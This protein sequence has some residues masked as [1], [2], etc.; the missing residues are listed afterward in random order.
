MKPSRFT[1]EQMEEFVR[2]GYWGKP[3]ISDLWEEN[4]GKYPNEEALADSKN[5]FTWAEAKIWFNRV[6]LSLLE[7]GLKKDDVVV[8]QLPNVCE[9]MLISHALDRAGLLG[10]PTQMTMRHKEME[11]ILTKTGAVAIV[12]IPFFHNF[13]YYQ[14]IQEVRE[15]FPQLKY[16][17]S[18]GDEIPEGA[19]SVK[20]MAETPLEEKYPAD[21][22]EKTKMGPFDLNSL[23]MTSGTTGFPKFVE[24]PNNSWLT[25]HVNAERW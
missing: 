12:I 13:D 16:I 14:M 20:K 18:V 9:N 25:G 22:L 15:G 2:Q 8:T 1:Q 10:L 11:Y 4:A 19:I 24:R 5:R 6:A 3:S 23:A 17:L 7:L 21:H